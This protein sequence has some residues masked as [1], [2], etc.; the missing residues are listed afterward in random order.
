MNMTV[1]QVE[2]VAG[3]QV[4]TKEDQMFVSDLLR[5]LSYIQNPSV[6]TIYDIAYDCGYASRHNP[7]VKAII[8]ISKEADFELSVDKAVS[9]II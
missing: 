3:Q 4:Q 1:N 9:T 7:F 5:S 6:K 8:T 2:D